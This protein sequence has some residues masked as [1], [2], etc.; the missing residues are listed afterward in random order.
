MYP[1]EEKINTFRA[2]QRAG[3]KRLFIFSAMG[4]AERAFLTKT[5]FFGDSHL[6]TMGKIGRSREGGLLQSAG[7]GANAPP[8]RS[9][10]PSAAENRAEG[11]RASELYSCTTNTAAGTRHQ[12]Q[13]NLHSRGCQRSGSRGA[14]RRRQGAQRGLL[15][16]EPD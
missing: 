5:T 16:N 12:Q 6:P 9:S 10:S 8:P 2:A 4:A 1:C 3:R 15:K 14:A 7:N 11:A 13:R